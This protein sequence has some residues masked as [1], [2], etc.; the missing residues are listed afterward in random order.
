MWW[1]RRRRI[2]CGQ[3]GDQVHVPSSTPHLR[4]G[5]C[6]SLA[7]H[8]TH[9]FPGKWG[10]SSPWQVLLSDTSEDNDE[11]LQQYHLLLHSDDLLSIIVSGV[12]Q[13]VHTHTAH[14]FTMCPICVRGCEGRRCLVAHMQE[15]LLACE[16]CCRCGGGV[17]LDRTQQDGEQPP[18]C[19]VHGPPTSMACGHMVCS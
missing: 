10:V 16:P 12:R 3:R 1:A 9:P 18:L 17:L 11:P 19:A 4:G 2:L 14:I 7:L 6:A 13:R 8:T 15:P 5:V